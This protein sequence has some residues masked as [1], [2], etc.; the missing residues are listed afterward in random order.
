[1][2]RRPDHARS[3]T[4]SNA[5]GRVGGAGRGG[6][7]ECFAAAAPGLEPIV[8]AELNALGVTSRLEEGGA[9]FS[10]TIEA[11]A[12]ANLWLRTASRLIVRVATFRAQAFHELERLARAIAWDRF[13]RAGA[14][15]RFRVTSRK[16]RLYHTGAI[17]QRFTEAIEHRLGRASA[18]AR[19]GSDEDAEDASAVPQLFVIRVVHDVFTVSADSSGL[20]LHQRGYRQAI[21]KAPLR[22]TLAAAVL[23]ASGWDAAAGA[24][25]LDPLCGS[26]TIPIEGALIARRIAPGLRRSFAF[27]DWPETDAKVWPRV[28]A[29]AEGLVLPS[30]PTVLRGSDRDAGAIEAARANAERA[31]VSADVEL[32]VRAV[33][34][35]QPESDRAGLVA[36]NPPYGVRVGDVA[37]LR[38]LYARFGQVLRTRFG[39]WR[40][41]ILSANPR[42][43]AELRLPLKEITRT[44]NGGI[45][46]RLVAGELPD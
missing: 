38:D 35:V 7:L 26:G 15:V 25:L 43:D 19:P 1:V 11:V 32:T 46:V 3:A 13:I 10:G 34:A 28:K 39:G 21:G 23:I 4:R 22:E 17:E 2:P 42:L 33:S 27:L 41:A 44:R 31:G 24:P 29:E 14:A 40:V 45:P 18:V 5:P 20:L 16:S 12:R 30:A 37:R 8:A 36:T 9:A 6:A